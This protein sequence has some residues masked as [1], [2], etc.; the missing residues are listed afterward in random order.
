MGKATLLSHL[1]TM[2]S[3]KK[4]KT[5]N[6]AASI[7]QRVKV[8]A[9][10]AGT[11]IGVFVEKVIQVGLAHPEEVRRLLE[12]GTSPESSPEKE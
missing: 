6:V 4:T 1:P 9:A 10:L 2:N 7:H 11:E 12:A 3:Q 5:L 8:D